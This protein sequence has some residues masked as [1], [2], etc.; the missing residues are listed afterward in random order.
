MAPFFKWDTY[1][2]K[3]YSQRI[4][5]PSRDSP[6]GYCNSRL[7][8]M[9]LF[10]AESAAAIARLAF[11]AGYMAPTSGVSLDVIIGVCGGPAPES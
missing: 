10:H 8:D 1:N 6:F 7:L 2:D 5:Q 9:L 3:D 11:L 4:L